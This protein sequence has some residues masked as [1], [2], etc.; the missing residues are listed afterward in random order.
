[1][2]A[3]ALTGDHPQLAAVPVACHG[4]RG[5]RFDRRQYADEAL[6]EG[7]VGGDPPGMVLLGQAPGLRIRLL[8]VLVRGTRSGGDLLDVGLQLLGG[9]RDM[10]L[11]VLE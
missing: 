6:G 3:F 8:Q 5:A 1:M 4:H 9:L 2:Q 10:G 11:E 7:T